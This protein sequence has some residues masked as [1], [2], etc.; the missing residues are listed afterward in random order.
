MNKVIIYVLIGLLPCS[1]LLT[2]C[3]GVE[4]KEKPP[5][6]K[7]ITRYKCPMGCSKEIFKKPG[8]CPN[9]GMELVKITEG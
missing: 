1:A 2:G 7:T 8:K 5:V 4:K 6:E 3:G 9:C